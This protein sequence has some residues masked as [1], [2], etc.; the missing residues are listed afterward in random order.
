MDTAGNVNNAVNIY[1]NRIFDSNYETN[2]IGKI[3]NGDDI[4]FLGW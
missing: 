2:S 3:I 4:L 1:D